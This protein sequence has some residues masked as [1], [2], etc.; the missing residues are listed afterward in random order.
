MTP[1]KI[2]VIVSLGADLTQAA[3]EIRDLGLETCQ[4]NCW[5]AALYTEEKANEV[6]RALDGIT[7]ASLW[8]GWPG[9]VAWDFWAAPL[10]DGLVPPE[11]R[12]I[13][14]QALKQAADFA[15]SL[16]IPDITTHAGFI[17]ENPA[18]AEYIKIVA[19]LREIAVHCKSKGVFFNFETGQET[20]ITLKRC[21][22]DIGTDNLGINLDPANLL[23]YGK[24]NP[25]DSVCVFG[26]YVRA[27]H[28]KDGEYPTNGMDLGCERV[29]GEGMVDFKKLLSSL[30]SKGFSGSLIIERE[31]SGPQQQV[32]VIKAR[33]ML[34]ELLAEI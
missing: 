30:K 28:V 3:N 34:I 27:L 7:I 12:A 26:E 20:P 21:I 2:G 19:A 29:V 11:Y 23:M 9:P 14:I 4:I 16:S 18:D 22:T 5:D 32:D 24:G 10:V 31:I 13:R 6:R 15:A 17:P 33:D 25:V 8:A 1:D